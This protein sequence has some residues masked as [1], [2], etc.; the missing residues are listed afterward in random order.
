M[1]SG[2]ATTYGAIAALGAAW[3]LLRKK[4]NSPQYSYTT[5]WQ[6]P[7]QIDTQ[8]YNY[9]GGYGYGFYADGSPKLPVNQRNVVASNPLSN[10]P[11]RPSRNPIAPIPDEPGSA[12]THQGTIDPVYVTP[13][14][15][16]GG[17][18][19][20]YITPEQYGLQSTNTPPATTPVATVTTYED[21]IDISNQLTNDDYVPVTQEPIYSPINYVPVTP[22]PVDNSIPDVKVYEGDAIPT[23]YT[24]TDNSAAL[25]TQ[26]AYYQQQQEAASEYA[27]QAYA[28]QQ[29]AA[30]QAY[31]EQ[32][33]AAAQAYADQ[34]AAQAY[35]AQQAAAAQAAAEEQA[36][37]DAAQQAATQAAA[38][39]AYEQ[40][41][42]AAAQ[43]AYEQQQQ[44]AAVAY[45]EQQAQIQQQEQQA[46][47][48]AQQQAAAQAY[49]E[50]QSQQ[51]FYSY[52]PWY[53]YQPIYIGGG[54]WGDSGMYGIGEYGRVS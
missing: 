35:A 45:A 17:D 1:N 52:Q 13:E 53:S 54:G 32:Q 46:A 31:A 43:A 41:Q 3:L 5:Y 16:V 39:A 34:Q 4:N 21:D 19:P 15:Y 12:T 11:Y 47:Y 49:Q 10:Q 23:D 26:A 36:R 38:Q 37:E 18:N 2:N 24:A 50:Q 6:Y 33:A 9:I 8:N 29:L 20:V 28:A 30:S 7:N 40:Q 51:S 27:A 22:P 48:Y 44:Q 25:A 14:Q 42:Q